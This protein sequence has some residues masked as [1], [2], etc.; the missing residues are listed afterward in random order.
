MLLY[1]FLP[2]FAFFF[3][4]FLL[5]TV[6]GVRR[7]R[8]VHYALAIFLGAMALWGLL[9]FWMRGSLTLEAALTWERLVLPLFAVISYSFFFFT[10][11][12]IGRS[13]SRR[14]WVGICLVGLFFLSIAP[15]PWVLQG[16][17]LRPYGYAPIIGPL[18]FLWIAGVYAPALVSFYYLFRF[19]RTTASADMRNR[20]L[21][22]LAGVIFSFLGATSDY[23][24]AMGLLPHPGGIYGNIL[25]AALV[26]VAVVRHHLVD[27]R[28]YLRRGVAYSLLSF[29]II[30]PYVA[31]I[32]LL[33][34]QFQIQQ[35]PLW[36]NVLFIL[37]LAVVLHVLLRRFQ[38]VVDRWF[39]RS[40]YDALQALHRFS[41]TASHT[42]EL[43]ELGTSLI[44]VV[45]QAMAVDTVHLLLYLPEREML[46]LSH[47]SK[48]KPGSFPPFPERS[49]LVGWLKGREGVFYR[50]DM[51]MAPVLRGL[52]A[53]S[54][55]AID[56]LE[57]QLFI[58]LKSGGRLVGVLVLGLRPSQ[59]PY[60]QEDVGILVT[61][62]SQAAIAIENA[63]V[64]DSL[65][66]ERLRVFQLLSRTVLAQEDER[67]R[68]SIELHDSVAQWLVG[69]S[70]RIQHSQ[71]LLEESGDHQAIRELT[72]IENT[73][74]QILK[75]LRRVMAGLHPPALDELGLAHALRQAV[76][77]LKGDGIACRVETKGTPVRLPLSVEIAVYRLVQEALT[78]V[79]KHAQAT[80]VILRM[81]FRVNDISIEIRDNGKGFDLLTTMSSPVSEEHMGLFG[82]KERASMLGGELRI[83]TSLGAGTCVKLSCPIPE[84]SLAGSPEDQEAEKR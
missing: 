67:K 59:E 65:E 76:E 36:V 72:E 82:M 24:A 58:T 44:Q 13:L 68:I 33:N 70:Y 51:E 43:E 15:T 63:R 71:R 35:V 84:P 37:A 48:L 55:E 4:S 1:K 25:F 12:F 45:R 74:D 30:L 80:K 26:T 42:L 2:L 62:A 39:Y 8:A 34:R 79:R 16:M 38:A 41:R 66:R 22:V 18:W 77:R 5:Y 56:R 73:V 46:S 50:Q 49:L 75:E 20:A 3:Q 52:P 28:I 40:R 11:L 27:A 69:A 81:N 32:V 54:W 57:G 83:E 10:V 78:N 23:V 7:K 61:V 17:Q 53:S 21:Y 29:A 6:F 19:S 47:S 14:A 9:I 64:L 60:T 31:L